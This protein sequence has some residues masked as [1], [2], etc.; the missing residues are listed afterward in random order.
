MFMFIL[1]L[2]VLML[3]ILNLA[4]CYILQALEKKVSFDQELLRKMDDLFYDNRF[5]EISCFLQYTD[6]LLI[7]SHFNVMN[8]ICDT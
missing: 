3:L 6:L 5:L 8:S 7:G 2:K 4:I 1:C